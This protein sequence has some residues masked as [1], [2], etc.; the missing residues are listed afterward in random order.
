MAGISE[1]SQALQT[2]RENVDKGGETWSSAPS[3]SIA[4]ASHFKN[5]QFAKDGPCRSEWVRQNTEEDVTLDALQEVLDKRGSLPQHTPARLEAEDLE[6]CKFLEESLK[7][8]QNQ[9]N[10]ARSHVEQ[11]HEDLN[12]R[13]ADV[14]ALEQHLRSE[15]AK[16]KEL[17][18][19]LRNYPRP[20]WLRSVEG[21]LNVAI[22]GNSGVGKSL[23]INKLRKVQPGELSWA[24]TGVKETTMAP[25]MYIFPGKERFR[26]W[27][28]PGADTT[29][30]PRETYIRNMG[31]RYFDSVLI[32]T[33]TRFTTMELDLMR[34][35]E[36]HA[37]PYCMV[38]TKI[39]IDVWN[40]KCDNAANEDSTLLAIRREYAESKIKLY[41]VSSRDPDKY[42]MPILLREAF[43]MLRRELNPNAPCYVPGW[44]DEAWTLTVSLS[45]ILASI[46]GQ[47]IDAHDGC[48][49]TIN[50]N[51]THI[52]L[53]DGQTAVVTLREDNSGVLWTGG[54][55]NMWR[56]DLAAATKGRNEA[57]LR[58]SPMDLKLKPLVWYW[59]G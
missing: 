37:I 14:A 53:V 49:Y 26:L 35:L 52:T 12:K 46:Q 20:D 43:P 47:W 29:N 5:V 28:L 2:R 44:L 24:P 48:V 33:A 1:L 50:A 22:T 57:I 34:E 32:V 42:D 8:M 7:K 41:C 30:F 16:R 51:E 18:E 10:E 15:E 3:V 45:P 58:W 6:R 31:L 13:E 25:T 40:N 56:L 9:L 21:S 17:E 36:H 23:L 19:E 11:K 39:D 4:D 59:L 55:E 27:D 54:G 38:R